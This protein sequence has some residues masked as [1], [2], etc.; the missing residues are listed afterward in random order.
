LQNDGALNFVHFFWT[1]LYMQKFTFVNPIFFASKVH[2]ARKSPAR[3][4]NWFKLIFV[5]D[6]LPQ[7]Q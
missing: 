1:T 3:L 5:K 2:E 4:H 7:T 6:V